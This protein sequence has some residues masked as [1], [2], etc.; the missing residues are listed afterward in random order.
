MQIKPH[1]I[2]HFA[3]QRERMQTISNDWNAEPKEEGSYFSMRWDKKPFQFY[4][5]YGKIDSHGDIHT[6]GCFGKSI[7]NHCLFYGLPNM[8]I[9]PLWDSKNKMTY[10]ELKEIL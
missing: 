4:F 7:E 2:P 1:Q 5:D 8:D 10:E 6:N 9:Q 3:R